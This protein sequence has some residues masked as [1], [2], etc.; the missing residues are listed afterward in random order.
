MS[1]QKSRL[2]REVWILTA[3][4]FFVAV[5]YGLIVPA[6]PLFAQK[7]HANNTQVGLIIASFGA[8]RFFSALVTGPLVDRFGERKVLTIGLLM[9]SLSCLLA[10]LSQNYIELLSFRTAGGLGSSMFSVSVGALLIRSVPSSKLG[11]AQS[12]YNGGF[13]VGGM[14]GPAFG[15]LLST[16]SLRAPFFVY[17]VTLLISAFISF[18]FL[19]TKR[20][21]QKIAPKN[22]HDRI[23]TV[24][25]AFSHP[26]FRTALIIAFL[27]NFVIFGPRNSV[28]PLYATEHLGISKASLGFSL[29]LA[30]ILQGGLIIPAGKISDREG[31]RFV[32]LIGACVLMGATAV[33]SISHTY[34]I[35][36][37]SMGL[38]GLGAAFIASTPAAIVGDI[39]AGRGGR[40]VGFSQMAGDAGMIVAPL[41]VGAL[42]DI[43]T[44][45][46]AF[47]VTGVIYLIALPTALKL[48]KKL[49]T[50]SPS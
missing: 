34:G 50:A 49:K 21:G 24:K 38:Y 19:S 1:K 47:V 27:T 30:A 41:V 46:T 9:I 44:Y 33:L 37:L 16:I 2:A 42:S 45:K 6:M 32:A 23:V 26:Q 4:G 40:V 13:I 36:S 7:F 48:P 22:M 35:F 5:G 18:F 20:L 14:A 8:A 28:I 29:T 25:E 31:R 11:H 39:F 12:V 43:F 17:A 15:G 3:V 10:G